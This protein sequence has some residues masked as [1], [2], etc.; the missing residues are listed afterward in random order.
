[1][2]SVQPPTNKR[3]NLK[4]PKLGDTF[5]RNGM[6]F[7]YEIRTSIKKGRRVDRLLPVRIE[8]RAVN[9]PRQV[10]TRITT[11]SVDRHL[12]NNVS[13]HS[14]EQRKLRF[15]SIQYQQ[16]TQTCNRKSIIIDQLNKKIRSMQTYNMSA[17]RDNKQLRETNQE[18]KLSNFKLKNANEEY[19]SENSKLK[20]DQFIMQH[21]IYKQQDD[22]KILNKQYGEAIKSVS[23]LLVEKSNFNA[24]RQCYEKKLS[25]LTNQMEFDHLDSCMR[26][27]D[28]FCITSSIPSSM[29]ISSHAV[30]MMGAEDFSTILANN[31]FC[32][33]NSVCRNIRYLIGADIEGWFTGQPAQHSG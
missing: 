6:I 1:M 13:V 4:N 11:N 25:I 9:K 5:Q 16:L 3:G 2:D 14:Y 31:S 23:T 30:C 22:I 15:L 33:F 27:F 8:G 10:I 18:L 32:L 28:N 17:F 26:L 7:Q 29:A 24:E 12:Y 21:R 20:I 19:S